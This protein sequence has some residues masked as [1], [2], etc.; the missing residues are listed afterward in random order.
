MMDIDGLKRRLIAE[1]I[2]REGDYVNHPADRGGPTRW[3][4]TEEVARENGY[5]GDM[6]FLPRAI[7]ARIYADRYWHSLALDE[8]VGL[9]EELAMVL[10]DFGVNSGPGRAAEYLQIQLNVLNDRERLYDDIAEDGDFG[11]M[12]L[13]A[14]RA[15]ADAR[16]ATSRGVG[17]LAHTMNA[18]RIVFCRRICQRSESQ[19]AFAYG[20]FSR[21]VGLLD[22]VLHQRPVPREWIETNAA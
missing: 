20:W 6:R 14:L 15:F 21:V 4:I 11:S 13:S 10:F 12:T 3:G 9:S 17:V 18:E 8:V 16:G 19:E 2:D 22:N 1:V 5:E 7:A